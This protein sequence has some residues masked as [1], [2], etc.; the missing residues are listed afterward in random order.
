MPNLNAKEYASFESIKR[1]DETGAEFW[2]ARELAPM[3]EYI[4][5]RNFSKVIDKAMLA[6]KNSGYDTDQCFA[7]VSKTSKMPNGG[8]KQVIDYELTKDRIS[9]ADAANEAH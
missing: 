2:Y 9:T 7:E 3:L 1:I 6:C 8:V 4:Q 5:W